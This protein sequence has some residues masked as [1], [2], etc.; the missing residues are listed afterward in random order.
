MTTTFSSAGAATPTTPARPVE[1]PVGCGGGVVRSIHLERLDC[2]SHEAAV[3]IEH[4]ARLR[5]D[6]GHAIKMR[7]HRDVLCQAR[8]RCTCR[9]AQ[10]SPFGGKAT[11]VPPGT[12]VAQPPADETVTGP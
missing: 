8:Y 7:A 10:L 12:N 1:R 2:N 6:P 3:L 11:R 9:S 4:H 5:P